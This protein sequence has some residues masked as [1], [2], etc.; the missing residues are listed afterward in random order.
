LERRVW[1]G[2]GEALLAAYVFGMLYSLPSI[3]IGKFGSD[4]ASL[5]QDLARFLPELM[6]VGI[7]LRW[8]RAFMSS[9]QLALCLAFCCQKLQFNARRFKLF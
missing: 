2:I 7:F 5:I 4:G 9:F 1:L 3:A 6:V 8:Q